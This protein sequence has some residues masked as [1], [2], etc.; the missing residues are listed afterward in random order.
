MAMSEIIFSEKA[1]N[2]LNGIFEYTV[3][4]WSEEQAVKY[5]NSLI[6]TCEYIAGSSSSIGHS[7][8]EVRQGL[9]GY[10]CGKH[11]I[12]YRKLS[13]ERIRIVRIL[14]EKMDFGGHL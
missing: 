3:K 13:S 1:K 12:F 7:Y 8:S 6:D 10:H 5:Y 4:T 14:H 2:D 11:V 9:F